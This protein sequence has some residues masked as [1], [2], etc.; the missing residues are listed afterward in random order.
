MG[1]LAMPLGQRSPQRQG[2]KRFA[3]KAEIDLFGVVRIN[4][5]A[6]G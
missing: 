6:F 2:L 5:I 4:G 1:R 3:F